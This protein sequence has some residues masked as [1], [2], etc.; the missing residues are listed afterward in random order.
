VKKLGNEGIIFPRDRDTLCV[1]AELEAYL[2]LRNK[3]IDKMKYI[4]LIEYIDQI[5]LM[6]LYK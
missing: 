3:D 1:I 4:E 6:L 2:G 5:T